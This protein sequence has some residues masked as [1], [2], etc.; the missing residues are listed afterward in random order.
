VHFLQVDVFADRPYTGN[1]LAVF[2][3]AGELSSAQMQAIASE[4]NLSETVFVTGASRDTYDVRI[5]TPKTELGFAGHPT[6]GTAWSLLHVDAVKGDRL[7]Q[8]SSAGATAV[9]VGDDKIWFE[10][11]GSARPDIEDNNPDSL[12]R[13]ASWVGLEPSAAGLEARELGRHGRLRPAI[14]DAGLAHLMLPVENLSALGR[15]VPPPDE[16]TALGIG[17]IYCFTAVRAGG[18][19]ARGLF[20]PSTGAA[21]DP[22][23]GSAAASLGLYLADR[24]GDIDFEIEQGVELGRPCR[25]DVSGREGSVRV[26]GRCELVLEGDLRHLP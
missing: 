26:G 24:I 21:E 6:I 14:A 20:P 11:D 19:R 5:F 13:V 3:D 10:R 2:P 8:R 23:T 17:G 25:I 18:V 9:T 15:C 1:P 7:V 16:A 22:G 12:R 4:M